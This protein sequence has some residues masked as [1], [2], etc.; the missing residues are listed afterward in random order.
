MSRKLAAALDAALILQTYSR[1]VI[2]CNRPVRSAD[3]IVSVSERTAIPGNLHVSLQ[4]GEQRAREIFWPY[5]DRIR[6]TLDARQTRR[7]P[8]LLLAMHS[9][10]ARYLDQ[11]RPWHVGV[12][13]NRDARLA[14]F[15]LAA[16]RREPDVV[17]G[18]NEPYTVSD[19]TDFAIPEYGE[20]RGLLHAEI[21]I[22]QDLIADEAG[23]ERWAQRLARLLRVLPGG[24]IPP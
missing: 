2:D 11:S 13:Y 18:D 20:R 10:T 8:T 21:E 15:L 5:H 12:L 16:L 6:A 1:L 14:R 17:V 23:Q 22:R 3:S 4:D 7:Q 19:D 24:F 9:F